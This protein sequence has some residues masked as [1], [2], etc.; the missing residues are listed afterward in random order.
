MLNEVISK[1]RHT[2]CIL[3]NQA[4]KLVKIFKINWFAVSKSRFLLNLRNSWISK[5]FAAML[6]LNR[7]NSENAQRERVINKI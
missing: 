4:V 3:R 1:N 6:S 2:S 7:Q 5:F